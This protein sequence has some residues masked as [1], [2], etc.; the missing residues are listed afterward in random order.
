MAE[1]ENLKGEVLS[2]K[3]DLLSKL[4]Q[5]QS[6]HQESGELSLTIQQM[7]TRG[8]AEKSQLLEQA[9][10]LM[11]EQKALR[12]DLM[13]MIG[14]AR[15]EMMKEVQE[16]IMKLLELVNDSHRAMSEQRL[17]ADMYKRK[18]SQLLTDLEVKNKQAKAS[19]QEVT[20]L[21]LRVQT[22]EQQVATGSSSFEAL[23]SRQQA[24]ATHFEVL[25]KA[26]EDQLRNYEEMLKTRLQQHS[27]LQSP[28]SIIGSSPKPTQSMTLS[29]TLDS[30]HSDPGVE[31]ASSEQVGRANSEPR[32]VRSSAPATTPTGAFASIIL[33]TPSPQPSVLPPSSLRHRP[34]QS[35]TR[36]DVPSP[37]FASPNTTSMYSSSVSSERFHT[38]FS[39]QH[40]FSHRAV[41]DHLSDAS[42]EHHGDGTNTVSSLDS[43]DSPVSDG[44]SGPHT[45]YTDPI[46]DRQRYR[47]ANL[48]PS[49][50]PLVQES[51]G[52][53]DVDTSTMM[54][55]TA[56]T[57]GVVGHES[58]EWRFSATSGGSTRLPKAAGSTHHSS[59]LY[60]SGA[61]LPR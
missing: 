6:S 50:H 13:N 12:T 46:L 31:Q 59:V 58:G 35:H 53:Y 33:N 1:I 43:L 38:P 3:D 57:R 44:T 9:R 14:A 52:L 29:A 18:H 5:E 17:Q 7:N 49:P 34:R 40:P 11:T 32:R 37:A 25:L 24:Q 16:K 2:V 45:V 56:P 15:E 60:R 22:L 54:E 55:V 28:S 41:T 26:K 36:M 30:P 10:S 27:A 51:S 19:K 42:Q 4:Q 8:R 21:V 61:E 47:K 23:A 39:Y 48:I 20:A